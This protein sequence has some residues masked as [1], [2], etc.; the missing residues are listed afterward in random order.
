MKYDGVGAN[1]REQRQITFLLPSMEK[2]NSADV[3]QS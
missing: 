1:A 2:D 3:K